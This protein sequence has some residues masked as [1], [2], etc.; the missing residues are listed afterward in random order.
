[1]TTRCF[2]T[3]LIGLALLGVTTEWPAALE[4]QQPLQMANM[5]EDE[6]D[7]DEDSPVAPLSGKP[8]PGGRHSPLRETASE[9][10]GLEKTKHR[11]HGRSARH[12]RRY[13]TSS[14]H[15]RHRSHGAPRH[16]QRGIQHRKRHSTKAHHHRSSHHHG[17][18]HQVAHQE[19]R[20]KTGHQKPKNHRRGRH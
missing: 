20:T 7:E 16:G 17:S 19:K 9:Q 8:P 13:A 5:E 14:S 3:M 11:H 2:P 15:R 10:G 18:N 12:A 1:M 4:R 6:E